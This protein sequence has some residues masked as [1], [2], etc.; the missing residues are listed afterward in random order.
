MPVPLHPRKAAV[1]SPSHRA[2]R[3]R[4]NF[5][6]SD[7]PSPAPFASACL[8]PLAAAE[9]RRRSA[10]AGSPGG[11]PISGRFPDQGS[12]R[13]PRAMFRS[14]AGVGNAGDIGSAERIRGVDV[15]RLGL[16]VDA[17]GHSA[18][19]GSQPSAP[20]AA[21]LLRPLFSADLSRRLRSGSPSCAEPLLGNGLALHSESSTGPAFPCCFT[22]EGGPVI[23]S[24]SGRRGAIPSR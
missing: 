11:R 20:M 23:A 19:T 15:V 2:P 17:G 6:S 24:S 9:C 21:A 18:W 4:I 8:Y 13:A 22:H 16:S 3:F 12:S 14:S 5:V 7:V 10:G 1:C